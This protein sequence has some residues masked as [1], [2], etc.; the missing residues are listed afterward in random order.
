MKQDVEFEWNSAQ[1]AAFTNIKKILTCDPI[2]TY[3]DVNK[4]MTITFDA[5]HSGL[6]SVLSQDNKPVAYASRSMTDA[7]TKYAQIEKELLA[8]LFGME[9]FLQY[10]YGKEVIVESDHKPIEMIHQKSLA[11]SPP[12]LKGML[13]RLQRYT[14]TVRYKPGPERHDPDM[15]SKAYIH[16]NV[17]IKLE[18]ALECHVHLVVR[19]LPY[20]DEKIKQMR[21]ATMIDNFLI[22]I[23]KLIKEGWPDHRSNVS[24]KAREY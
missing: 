3:Y 6:E 16:L 13:L 11:S 9:R 24:V 17:D 20:S 22:V 15:L 5:S 10:T 18:E 8:I 4:E 12:R 1:E 7:E 21:N 14:Y 19:S 2:L 23:S